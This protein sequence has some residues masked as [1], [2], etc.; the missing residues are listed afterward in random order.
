MCQAAHLKCHIHILTNT[1]TQ[2]V[3]SSTDLNDNS[4]IEWS[5][6]LNTVYWNET[7]AAMVMTMPV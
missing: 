1:K 6:L 5:L 7:P 3:F 4:D 2:L